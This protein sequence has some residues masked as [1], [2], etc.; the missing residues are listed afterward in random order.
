MNAALPTRAEHEAVT[1]TQRQ[2]HDALERVSWGV[3]AFADE[4]E[5]GD[6]VPERMPTTGDVGELYLLA[7]YSRLRAAEIVSLAE[8]I[9]R[10]LPV[11]GE[12]PGN[13]ALNTALP[14]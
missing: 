8:A 14:A 10:V 3:K 9:E 6:N 13:V 1:E 2:A 4:H 5:L 7:Y 11:L 12:I